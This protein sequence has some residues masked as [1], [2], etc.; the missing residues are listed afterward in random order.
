M[1][2]VITLAHQK[3]GVG[4]S[5]LAVNLAHAF[6]D[7]AVT[8]IVDLD[9]QGSISQTANKIDGVSVIPLS[10]VNK[11]EYKA[12]FIDT[13]PYLSDKLGQ[14][15]SISDLIL[16]PTKAGIYDVLACQRTVELVKT[17]MSKKPSLKAAIVLNMVNTT[18]TL[19]SEAKEQL[20]HLGLP[21]L[22]SQITERMNFIRSIALPDGIYSTSD[23]KAIKEI[24]NLTKEILFLLNN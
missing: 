19:T 9:A 21:L 18:T 23:S 1:A 20:E 14:V 24:N 11:G 15:F 10:A 17:A 2:T 6:K 3:G 13:P 12:V 7:H 5:T 4:K 16:I 22:K 8:A